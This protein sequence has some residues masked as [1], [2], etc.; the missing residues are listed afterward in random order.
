MKKNT[1]ILGATTNENR[2]AY[3]AAQMLTEY[4][5]EIF[6]VGVKK[7]EVFGKNI[8]NS[9]DRITEEI[10]TVTLYINPQRQEEWKDFILES[11]P[12]RVIFNPGTEN[13]LFMDYLESKGIQAE[14]AC[15]LV[16]LSTE[17]Y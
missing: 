14:E 7:G 8:Q 17:Q 12:K 11:N 13:Q 1:L 6:P 15:T 3:H 9:K 2:Y 10:D 4:G 16:L 5:H